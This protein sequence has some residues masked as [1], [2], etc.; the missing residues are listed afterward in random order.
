MSERVNEWTC[1]RTRNQVRICVNYVTR[2]IRCN[3]RLFDPVVQQCSRWHPGFLHGQ[4]LFSHFPRPREHRHNYL[5]THRWPLLSRDMLTFRAP[6]GIHRRTYHTC[7]YVRTHACTHTKREK[8]K[9][10]LCRRWWCSNTW[11]GISLISRW[12]ILK[13]FRE[14]GEWRTKTSK[15]L[16]DASDQ[17]ADLFR[18]TPSRPRWFAR[19]GRNAHE[20]LA[21][22][23]GVF[24]ESTP[25]DRTPPTRV[26]NSVLTPT[27]SGCAAS[28]SSLSFYLHERLFTIVSRRLVLCRG[29]ISWGPTV[30][31]TPRP[32]EF[33]ACEMSPATPARWSRGR[34][35]SAG[36]FGSSSSYLPFPSSFRPL[37]LSLSRLVFSHLFVPRSLTVL[38]VIKTVVSLFFFLCLPF[39]LSFS[40]FVHHTLH[41]FTSSVPSFRNEEFF[42]FFVF[43]FL[44]F[45]YMYIFY[46]MLNNN[47]I[48]YMWFYI[49]AK[50]VDN[51]LITHLSLF[52]IVINTSFLL[53]PIYYLLYSNSVFRLLFTGAHRSLVN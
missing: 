30:C 31:D 23:R 51:R 36:S 22:R 45:F 10:T 28:W 12:S 29:D 52:E 1:V 46:E 47:S 15:Q 44:L 9:E 19:T 34:V 25:C 40:K 18:K 5:L 49:R 17:I 20:V 14:L 27:S 32:V 6:P 26:Y 42:S 39:F 43:L 35:R 8:E 2:K 16:R 41:T 24:R 7:T 3:P 11:N 13:T 21:H 50:H 38:V 53:S 48:S 37:S 33:W 4:S